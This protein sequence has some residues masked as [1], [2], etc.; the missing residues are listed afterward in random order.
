M[1]DPTVE[2]GPPDQQ[3]PP[4]IV[5]VLDAASDQLTAQNRAL[6]VGLCGALGGAPPAPVDQLCTDLKPEVYGVPSHYWRGDGNASDSIGGVDGTLQGATSFGQGEAGQ[7]FE[8]GS[9]GDAVTFGSDVGNFGTDDFTVDFWLQMT[10]IAD[11]VITKDDYLNSGWSIGVGDRGTLYYGFDGSDDPSLAGR[12][13]VNDGRLHHITFSRTR[14]T[15]TATVDG[16]DDGSMQTQSVVDLNNTADLTIA[17]D[18][19]NG[20]WPS[21]QGV[22]DEVKLFQYPFVYPGGASSAAHRHGAR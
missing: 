5:P 20:E 14:Q 13:V 7:A 6:A 17:G 2:A 19:T 8:F 10:S 12:T 9:Q 1:G 21:F 3:N 4:R 15:L 11:P 22:V 18:Q 16:N